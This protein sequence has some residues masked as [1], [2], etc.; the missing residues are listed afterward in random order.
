M[1][2]AYSGSLIDALGETFPKALADTSSGHPAH[3]RQIPC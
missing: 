2:K 3:N 1:D